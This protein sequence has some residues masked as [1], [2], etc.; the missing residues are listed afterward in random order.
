M[1]KSLQ[2]QV[3]CANWST[4][5]M[6]SNADMFFCFYCFGNKCGSG[7]CLLPIVVVWCVFGFVC[8][9]LFVADDDCLQCFELLYSVL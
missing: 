7:C 5:N 1:N 9:S 6:S 8:S 2:N 3:L 4:S